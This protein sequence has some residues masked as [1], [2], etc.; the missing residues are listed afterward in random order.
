L[1]QDKND[2]LSGYNCST[3]AHIT[4]EGM[5]QKKV[6]MPK[7]IGEQR[8]IGLFFDNLDNLITLH[9]REIKE[10]KK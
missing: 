8:Q 6:V 10:L 3:M 4:K 7:S 9:Q 1:E 2:I 5:E